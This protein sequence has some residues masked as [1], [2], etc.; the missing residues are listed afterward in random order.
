MPRQFLHKLSAITRAK[1]WR[2]SFVPFIMGCVYLWLWWFRLPFSL[3][4]IWLTFL[5]LVTTV[6]FASLGYF[7]NEFFDKA[8]DAKAGKIN[9]L[10]HL[11]VLLQLAIFLLTV[12]LTFLPWLWLP[13][14]ALTWVLIALQI[15]LYLVYSLPFPRLKEAVYLSLPVDALY[16]YV[17]PLMLSFYTFSLIAGAPGFPVWLYV[18]A[19][20][21]LFIG[22][23][24]IIIHQVVDVLKDERTGHRTLPMT[25]GVTSTHR[26]IFIVAAYE[27]FLIALWSVVMCTGEPV[28]L[29]WLIP[30]A[31][32]GFLTLRTIAAEHYSVH[33]DILLIN[34]AYQYLFPL[35]M[36]VFAITHHSG[37]L[38]LLLLHVW[39]LVPFYILVKVKEFLKVNFYRGVT[40][41][42]V[43]VRH[44]FSMTVNL[45]VYYFFRLF[46]VDLVK[47][48]KSG[49]EYLLGK[50]GKGKS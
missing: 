3:Q 33:S 5:S 12:A 50:L 45:P 47:E 10:T 37:W 17:V 32:I 46:G 48:K 9:N 2:L 27:I 6:G 35:L 38:M 18:F 14:T 26:L 8:S 49:W 13:H 31:F 44:A 40:F 20:A 15:G 16:A 19:T 28:F 43:D 22:L 7:I 42:T 25:L 21:V 30:Y 36:L 4:I 39:L 29:L 24:N 23:R 34:R 1:D 41:V 11:S